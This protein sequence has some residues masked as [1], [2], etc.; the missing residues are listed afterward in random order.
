MNKSIKEN[1]RDR[2][3]LETELAR[4]L[5]LVAATTIIVGGIIGSGIFGAPADIAAAVGSP[6]LFLLVWMI[7]GLLCFSGALCFAE[8]GAMMP[9]TG[10]IVIY[11]RESYPPFVA[12]LYGWTEITVI[13]PG[14]LAAVAMICTTYV[15]YFIP[16]ISIE[17]ILLE[18]GPVVISTQHLAIFTILGL[19]GA[20]NYVGVRFGG[21]ISNMSTFAKIAALLGLIFLGLMGSGSVDHFTK[22]SASTKEISLLGALGV[23]MVGTLFSYNGWYNTNN[24]AGEVKDPRRVLPLAI[25]IGLSLCML[26]Y[27]AV[28]WT[29]LYVMDIDEIAASER[30][31]A[32]AAERLIGPLGGSLTSLAVI[33][34][35]LGTLN[36]NILYMPRIAYGMAREA[37]FFRWFAQ[38]HPQF[39]TPSRTIV[40]L[41]LC[42]MIWSLVGNFMEIVMAV[43]YVLF[44][45]YVLAVIAVFILRRRYPEKP[46]PFKVWGYPITPLFFIFV[47]TGYIVSTVI[48]NFSEALPGVIVLAL[49]VPVYFLWFR[50]YLLIS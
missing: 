36:A 28:N 41:I 2:F 13:S 32:E 44:V 48:F 30:I 22:A 6:M 35:T 14:A 1:S 25:I 38:V 16:G 45:F 17:N 12:F 19:L 29:Y 46:R 27:L 8:L 11:L 43:M 5:G 26:I 37:L 31:A 3:Q 47:S 34:A 23:A 40:T 33:L 24:V 39:R 10:G 50:R 42:G 9:R 18:I 15:G 49:G 4:D 7:G 20:V 21:L